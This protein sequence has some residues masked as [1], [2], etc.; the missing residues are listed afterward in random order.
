M[1]PLVFCVSIVKQQIRLYPY[2][3]IVA[4]WLSIL[5]EYWSEILD[6]RFNEAVD[7]LLFNHTQTDGLFYSLDHSSF[8]ISLIIFFR[9]FSPWIP[10]RKWRKCKLFLIACSLIDFDLMLFL[11]VI[12]RNLSSFVGVTIVW[13]SLFGF[14]C[15]VWISH[16]HYLVGFA[17][18]FPSFCFFPLFC[19]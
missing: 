18:F 11:K 3:R 13:R 15:L 14:F 1:V 9:I 16:Q 17:S 8:L 12:S 19:K 4:V 5:A 7:I 6:H 2:E 10:P